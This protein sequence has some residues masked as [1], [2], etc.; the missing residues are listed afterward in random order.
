MG[1]TAPET[2]PSRREAA[3]REQAKRDKEGCEVMRHIFI[4]NPHAGKKKS[5]K[6]LERDI[7]ALDVPCEII[8]TKKPGDAR[9]IAQMAAESGEEVRL[10]ACGGD[11]T[12][13]E[14][15]NGA[16]GFP[17]AAVNW[18]VE[19]G[20]TVGDDD[21]T[22]FHPDNFCARSHIVTF[23]FRDPTIPI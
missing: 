9:R 22:V 8:Y 21:G 2:S 10:Y 23:L 18:A 11:G 19:K 13:H 3:R 5:T 6:L 12:L 14:V 20:I 15:V 16:A 4:I 1:P 7:R 17:G